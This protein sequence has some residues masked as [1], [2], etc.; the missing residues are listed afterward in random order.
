MARGKKGST[1]KKERDAPLPAD[2][3]QYMKPFGSFII[4]D[5]DG[6][7]EYTF[8][9]EDIA[10]ILPYGRE[11]GTEIEDWEYWVA[12]IKDIRA[13]L[14]PDG[15]NTVWAK[16]QWFYSGR[17][18]ANVVK[19]FESDAI[20][21]FERIYA[22]HDD[23]IE[24][25]SVNSVVRVIEFDENDVE[26]EYIPRDQFYR[27]YTLEYKARTIKPK[28]GTSA[29]V[30][31]E[32]YNPNDNS[33]EMVMH[34]CPRPSCRRA[35][36][37]SCLLAGNHKEAKE[38]K[39]EAKGSASTSGS[40]IV[41]NPPNSQK[42]ATRSARKHAV[43]VKSQKA[44]TPEV[45]PTSAF[46][47]G[48]SSSSSSRALRL[49][50]CSPDTDDFVDL[51][52]LIPLTVISTA[53][54]DD[55]EAVDPPKKK[56]RGRPP[57]KAPAAP[58]HEALVQPPRSLA[59][60]LAEIPPELREIAEQPMVRGNAF[61]LGGVS[62]NIGFVTRARRLV[63]QILEGS[64]VPDDWMLQ[65]FASSDLGVVNAIVKIGGT[66]KALPPVICPNCK[67]AI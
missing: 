34:F 47:S 55:A 21:R 64:S 44:S 8:K 63:Y 5:K 67:S 4:N 19:S 58:S 33:P 45:Q 60:A 16:V 56:R 23:F 53:V 62:G 22:D 46:A 59:A 42:P 41:S 30:C 1:S 17:D 24:S 20:G 27:R 10:A 6:E 11:P 13:Q 36:H 12:K 35:Y 52:S 15:S 40:V 9:K 29:C 31:K 57:K 54:E 66:R 61:V 43:P 51:E 38:V 26:P 49:L 14:H 65:V 2:K 32:P 37:Q 50:A 7:L 3:W 25:E 28:P 18:V 48:S 39:R